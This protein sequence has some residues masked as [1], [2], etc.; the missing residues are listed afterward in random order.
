MNKWHGSRGHKKPR[1]NSRR[2]IK[3]GKFTVRT[4]VEVYPVNITIYT[5]FDSSD[6]TENG[7]KYQ[8]KHFTRTQSKAEMIRDILI[9]AKR[10]DSCHEFFNRETQT[11]TWCRGTDKE[12]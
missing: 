6:H 12:K 11:R 9:G 7:A 8:L 1:D 2:V 4:I 10:E 5:Y 3:V